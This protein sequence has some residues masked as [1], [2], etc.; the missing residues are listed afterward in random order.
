MLSRTKVPVVTLKMLDDEKRSCP[1][2]TPEGCIIY[3]DRPV[4]CRYYP[5]GM[6][7]FR[8]QE[9]QP[10]GEDFYFMVRESHCLG[11]RA[12]REWTVSEW[13]KDQGVEPYDEINS[14]WMELMLRKKSFG[15]QAELSEESRSMFFMVSSNVDKLRRFIFESSFLKKYDVEKGVLEKISTDEIALLKFGFDWLQSALF[16]ADKV[17]LREDVLKDYRERAEKEARNARR[18]RH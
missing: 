11:F 6:A 1:F 12:D 7:S 14:G 2:V 13:R 17:K 5:L 15:F 3:E 18:V 4:S 8:E 16:G 9:I 10:S